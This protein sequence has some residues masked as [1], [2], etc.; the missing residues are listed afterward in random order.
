M[1]LQTPFFPYIHSYTAVASPHVCSVDFKAVSQLPLYDMGPAT[2]FAVA[3]NFPSAWWPHKYRP[4][5]C[6]KR[7]KIDSFHNVSLRDCERDTS[8][9]IYISPFT[10][11]R[12]FGC[13]CFRSSRPF[14]RL[15]DGEDSAQWPCTAATDASLKEDKH[16]MSP[17][18]LCGFV[19]VF[20]TWPSLLL[21][22]CS[23]WNLHIY[24]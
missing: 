20:R 10:T 6:W 1:Q 2:H 12:L 14:W 4:I 17:Y 18:D 24:S 23:I 13:S 3:C 16:I 19:A 15:T 22:Y 5:C 21:M 9:H 11:H 8:A 7:L